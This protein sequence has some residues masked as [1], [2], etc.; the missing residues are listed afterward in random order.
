MSRK[1]AH[2]I[3]TRAAQKAGLEEG[4][5]CH[6]TRKYAAHQVYIRSGNCL[7]KTAAALGH[8]GGVATT[9][10]YIRGL[11]TGAESLLLQIE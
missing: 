4:I 11:A 8:R 5:S 6:S 2:Y 7:I 10:R 3:I 9:W 1:T